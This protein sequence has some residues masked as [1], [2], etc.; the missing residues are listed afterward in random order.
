MV[1]CAW[2]FE[3]GSHFQGFGNLLPFVVAILWNG[4]WVV[5]CGGSVF[6]M[7][8]ARK[9]QYRGT[10]ISLGDSKVLFKSCDYCVSLGYSSNGTYW[11]YCPE[12]EMFY[13]ITLYRRTVTLRMYDDESCT[14]VLANPE[15]CTADQADDIYRVLRD[16]SHLIDN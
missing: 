8:S 12:H 7:N 15:S 2:S 5:W 9:F 1:R 13:G 10:T 16:L 14:T 6:S 4:G 3:N 11:Y